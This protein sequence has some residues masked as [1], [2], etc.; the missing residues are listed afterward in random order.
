MDLEKALE[1]IKLQ[2]ELIKTMGRNIEIKNDI[3]DTLKKRTAMQQEVI[4]SF[5]EI[6]KEALYDNDEKVEVDV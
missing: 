3:I 6:C 2:K 5:Y 4:S 1:I